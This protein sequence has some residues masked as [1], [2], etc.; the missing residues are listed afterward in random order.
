MIPAAAGPGPAAATALG[1]AAVSGDAIQKKKS[2]ALAGAAGGAAASTEHDDDDDDHDHDHDEDKVE[3][4]RQNLAYHD[5]N[6]KTV[7]EATKIA[8]DAAQND[9]F[10]AVDKLYKAEADSP[11]AWMYL[12]YQNKCRAEG[13]G[14]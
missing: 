6:M 11:E 13:R 7:N 5:Q 14:H 8:M 1:V 4:A 3:L 10:E 12:Q 9:Y 2:G